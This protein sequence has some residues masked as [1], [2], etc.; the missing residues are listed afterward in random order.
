MPETTDT[1]PAPVRA[2]EPQPERAGHALRVRIS[3]RLLAAGGT[4]GNDRLPGELMS[5]AVSDTQQVGRFTAS[6]VQVVACLVALGL[7]AALL[8]RM[9]VPLGLLV[10]LGTPAV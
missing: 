4:A 6:I 7:G 2:T 5:V 8:L 10:V 9:S 3:G 1:P